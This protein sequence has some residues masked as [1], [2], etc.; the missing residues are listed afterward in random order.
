M[1]S[2]S[3]YPHITLPFLI[4]IAKILDVSMGTIRIV[5]ISKN[6]RGTAS[7]LSFFEMFIWIMAISNIMKNLDNLACCIAYALGYSAGVYFG[8]VIEERISSGELTQYFKKVSVF[9]RLV[10]ACFLNHGSQPH[11]IR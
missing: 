7:I 3:I 8:M 6:R 1:E 11:Q 4:F 2:L 9:S 10:P 5:L